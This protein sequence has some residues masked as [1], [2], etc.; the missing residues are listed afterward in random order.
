M[1][2]KILA[3]VI[4]AIAVTG[5]GFYYSLPS[6]STGCC[7]GKTN[8]AST[9][10]SADSQANLSCCPGDMETA[11]CPAMATCC[12]S[13]ALHACVGGMPTLE[14]GKAPSTHCCAE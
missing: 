13:E 7:K 4:A 1:L 9:Q 6:E 2:A 8:S 11:A 14:V 3:G 5:V 10:V 12:S